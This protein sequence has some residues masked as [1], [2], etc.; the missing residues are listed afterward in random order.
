MDFDIIELEWIS[1]F[2]TVGKLETHKSDRN[3]EIKSE[4]DTIEFGFHI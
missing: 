4:P 1:K 2:I 3:K